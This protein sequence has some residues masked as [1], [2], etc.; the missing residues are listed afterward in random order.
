MK[1]RR[2]A[3]LIGLLT[4]AVLTAG[5]VSAVSGTVRSDAAEAATGVYISELTGLPI[6]AA[7]Q[8]QRPVAIMVDNEKFALPH[9][10]LNQ[11]DI[12]YEMM[13]S[14]ANGRITR[15][16]AI[17]KDWG[18]ITQF[19]SIRST[20]PTNFML[21]A[22]YNAILVHDGGPYYNN[23]YQRLPYTN[24]LSAGFARYS[25]GKASEFTEYVTYNAYTNPTTG[26]SYSGLAQRIAAAGFST[27]YNQYYQG[28]NMVFAPTEYVLGEGSTVA[29]AVSLPFPHNSSKLNF[30]AATGTY[31]YSEYNKPHVDALT[32]V[33]TTFE[34]VL[35]LN[36]SFTQLD[37]N[38]Y[39]I[40]NILTPSNTG[41]YLANGRCI[42]ITW[43]KTS[44]CGRTMYTNAVTGTPLVFNPGKTYIAIVPSDV[45]NKVVIQ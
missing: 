7:L 25:N 20:R 2:F 4:A 23:M 45:W 6:S 14:T 8:N 33:Q 26:R 32:G 13:N 9:F 12:V 27:T 22:E 34:N 18:A 5:A 38:G 19:G 28:P 39:M 10:G 44:D 24:N 15:L 1:K 31:D 11:A 30:N 17:V 16:M 43:S 3:G 29:N 40:Y 21:A 35:V 42:P 36:C 41:Y 37:A